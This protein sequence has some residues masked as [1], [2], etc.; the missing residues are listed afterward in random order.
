M[1]V[2]QSSLDDRDVLH[3]LGFSACLAACSRQS[4]QL[5]TLVVRIQPCT[6]SLPPGE[7]A[8]RI[9][10][11]DDLLETFIDAFPEEPIVVCSTFT[12]WQRASDSASA[13]DTPP[14][15]MALRFQPSGWRCQCWP[16]RMCPHIF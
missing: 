15:D 10:N 2:I 9:D 3:M 7:Y 11:A 16:V 12:L 8:D 13:H 1:F 5:M 6:H 14:V 4:R